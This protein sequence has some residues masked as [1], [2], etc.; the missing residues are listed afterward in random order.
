MKKWT[1]AELD[2]QKVKVLSAQYG[3]PTFTAM[4]LVIRGITERETIETFFA[5][6]NELSDPFL[7][8]DM[9]KAVQRIRKA[10]LGFE[11][12]CVYGDYD[13]DGV[14]ATA[15]LYSYLES[16][17]ANV[18][19]YI[20]D[21][22]AEGYGMNCQAVD[23]LNS[24]GVKL[25]VTVDNGISAIDEIQYASTLGIDVVVTDHHKPQNILPSAVA[26]V[27]P[28]R[29]DDT[30]P[31]KEFAGAGVA[32]KLAAAIEGDSFAIMENYADLAAIG[33]VADLVPINGENRNIIK[34][35]IFN[36]NNT[37][38]VGIASLIESA[39]ISKISTGTIGFQLAPR[40]NAAGRLGT[41]YDALELFLTEDGEVGET[42]AEE[43]TKLNNER[44]SIEDEIAK[45]IAAVMEQDET[46]K[47]DRVLVLSSEGWNAGVIGIVAS[48]VTERFGKPSVLISEDGEVCRAS[49]RSVSGFSIV[50][51][52][53]ECEDL[54]EKYGGHPM[55]AGF[56]IKK[57]NIPAFRKRINDYA[58]AL[59]K[60]AIPTVKLDCNLNPSTLSVQMV[61]ELAEFEPFGYGNPRPIF[62][63]NKMRLDKITPLG[64][65]KHLKLS[66]SRDKARIS[67]LKFSMTPDEFPY[68]EGDILD[69]AVNL[70]LNQYRGQEELS[71]QAKDFRI[72]EFDTEN[73][74]YDIQKYELYKSGIIPKTL[75]ESDY[76]SRDE[77]AAVYVYIR[78]NPKA[79]YAIDALLS[80]FKEKNISSFKL[81]MIFDI[82]KELYLIEYR[83]EGDCIQSRLLEVGGKVDL[84][85][86]KI[87]RKLK[88]DTHH[89]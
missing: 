60:M 7:I 75:N 34:Q 82:M 19:Y 37:E 88:E 43:L 25:I 35:G 57:E 20:P 54:L 41:P 83:R 47:Y 64:G 13:C 23:K 16:S 49:C 39:G 31:F 87:Y 51:A 50:D 6:Q 36:I 67:V 15:I 53:F 85:A 70:D 42:K 11:K 68:S 45:K 71:I 58:N 2:K 28:H 61:H 40:I 14:T 22:N 38:R 17:G 69:L 46:L 10:V 52:I 3:L 27:N 55:A 62:G 66:M 89:A 18:M 4:L 81:L 24:E 44:R 32:L 48:R 84:N 86:S 1:T 21:R 63:L 73:A 59:E 80:L 9:D 29:E 74:M 78:K 26:V 77:F 65:G 5:A 8:K 79:M 72:A 56:S 12:I 33:T 30:S 76:P